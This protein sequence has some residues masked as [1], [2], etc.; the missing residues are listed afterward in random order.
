MRLL[1]DPGIFSSN[2]GGIPILFSSEFL[3]AIRNVFAQMKGYI[4]IIEA[5]G[6]WITFHEFGKAFFF[7]V[8]KVGFVSYT[9]ICR[10]P[11][12]LPEHPDVLALTS[13]E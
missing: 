10:C 9:G 7:V 4:F 3:Y 13:I 11:Y 1:A 2:F 6:A 5:K 8:L 12:P